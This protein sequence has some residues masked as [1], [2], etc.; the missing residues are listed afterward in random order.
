[1]NVLEHIVGSIR[2]AA[3]Y[4][5]HDAAP[6]SVIL[7]TDGPRLWESVANRV[8]DCLERFYILNNEVT[9]SSAG[10]STWIRY[11][12]TADAD[13]EGVPVVYLPG[14]SRQTFRSSTGF[15]DVAKH[16]FALQFLGQFWTQLNGKDWTPAALMSSTDGGLGLDLAKD[17]ATA[18]AL[19]TQW[20]AVLETPVDV[21]F[22]KRLEAADFNTLA[23]S[24]PDGM[25]L[26][27]MQDPE[28]VQSEWTAERMAAFRDVCKQKYQ[29]NP[30][31]EGKL[32]AAEKLV[33]GGGAWDGVWKRFEES[34]ATYRAVRDSLAL[35]K[36]MDLFGT[37]SLRLPQTNRDAEDRLRNDLMGLSSQPG[38]AVLMQLIQFANEHRERAASIWAQLGEAPLAQAVAHLGRM[39]QTIQQ[40][41]PGHDWETIARAYLSGG[42]Q[43]DAEARRS[44]AA[45]R[46]KVDA[47]A[48]TV[49]LR[50]S[51]LS[52]LDQQAKR[53]A[54]WANDYPTASASNARRLPIEPGL[55]YLFVDGLRADV[56]LDLSALFE[57]SGVECASSFNWAPLPTVTSTAKPGW[58]PL[59]ESLGGEILSEKFEPQIKGEKKSLTTEGF[60]SRVTQLGLVWF[61]GSET[62]NPAEAGWTETA[63]FDSRGHAEGAKLVWRIQE[64]LHVVRQRVGELL[65]AGWKKV[66]IITDHGWLWLPGGLPKTELPTHLTASKWGRCAAPQPG[67][68]HQLPS[69]PWFWANQHHIVLA[70]GVTAFRNGIEYAHGGLTIQEALTLMITVGDARGTDVANVSILS[71]RWL[72]LRLNVEI[73]GATSG[74]FV[75]IRTKAAVADSSLLD[76]KS[77][78]QP[79]RPDGKVSVI[80]S[81][82]DYAGAAAT[83]VLLHQGQVIA[84]QAVTVGEN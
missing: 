51:Y 75:D 68:Q 2:A 50:A 14:V 83:V 69:V 54:A 55:V 6:P 52:W 56:A 8:G 37:T 26:R 72:G 32:G 28:K 53:V 9:G 42:W 18:Q 35:V 78:S 31:T 1:M 45:V 24:D 34:P 10:P 70:P 11:R 40:G 67:A 47:D 39:A 30:A 41:F 46:N 58:H 36:P 80:I 13:K 7:W 23:V 21:F 73:Q 12:L 84:K 15:P 63:D 59:V 20:M 62:G 3:A 66:V 33:A 17:A 25:L 60:R 16:L 61:T 49:A 48:V 81:N 43:V 71:V 44:F 82:D 64:E 5:K 38:H 19:A 74:L 4:N 22:G 76:K 29:F 65:Q 27:W 79:I 77:T 57:N